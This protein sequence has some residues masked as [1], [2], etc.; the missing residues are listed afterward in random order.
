M[1][2]NTALDFNSQREFGLRKK[3]MSHFSAKSN[4]IS[5]PYDLDEP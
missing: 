2:K 1:H 5:N 3:L 4:K